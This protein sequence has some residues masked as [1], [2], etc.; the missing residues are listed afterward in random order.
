MTR[1]L[2]SGAERMI[3]DAGSDEA[4]TYDEP[5]ACYIEYCVVSAHA[6]RRGIQAVLVRSVRLFRWENSTVAPRLQF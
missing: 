2:R 3:A 5:K 6:G 4:L 1:T